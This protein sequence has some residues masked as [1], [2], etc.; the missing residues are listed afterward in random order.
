MNWIMSCRYIILGSFIVFSSFLHGILNIAIQYYY[1]IVNETE[2]LIQAERLSERT[3][4]WG[5]IV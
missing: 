3:L 4:N 5:A 1:T 2:L